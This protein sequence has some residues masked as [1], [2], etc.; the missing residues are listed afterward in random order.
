MTHANTEFFEEDELSLV[1]LL[2]VLAK[3]RRLILGLP[4]V[5]G[6]IAVAVVLQIPP[7]YTASTRIMPPVVNQSSASA[8]LSSVG[9]GIMSLGKNPSDIY[10][11]LI[12]SR[13]VE[14]AL[15][16]RFALQQYYDTRFQVDTRKNL[17]H[18]LQVSAGKEGVIEISYE[19]K[20]PAQAAAVANGVVVALTE[21]NARLAITDAARRRVY[22]QHQLELAKDNLSQ[23]EVSLRGYQEKTGVVELQAQG[24]ATLSQMATLEATITAREVQLQGMRSYATKNNPDYQRVQNELAGLKNEL[25][26]LQGSK[27]LG[28]SGAMVAKDKIPAEGMEFSHR[29]RDVKYYETLYEIM[30]KQFEM[31]KADEAKEGALIQVI[32]AATPPE[33]KSSP[34]RGMIVLMSMA[35]A[36]F[37]AILLAFVRSALAAGEVDPMQAARL[38]ELRSALRR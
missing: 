12:K 32:D 6:L 7:K 21:L 25:S 19:H 8:L 17:E 33:R 30:A 2:I 26:K 13:S 4:L 36:F 9:G 31:A 34:K 3:S 38:A 5:V 11:T 27:K 20:D 22:F 10:V 24:G 35:L 29:T 37:L 1:D 16:K 23:A 15:I 18:D 28:T 14:D